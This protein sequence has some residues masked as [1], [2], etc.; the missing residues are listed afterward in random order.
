MAIKKKRPTWIPVV[1]GLIRKN[2][3]LLVGLRPTG[4]S[5]AGVWEFPGGKVEPG[6]DPIKA[7]RRELSEELGIEADVGDLKFVSSHRYGETNILLMFFEVCYWRGE[8][9]PIHHQDLRW[10]SLS[11]LPKLELPEA[12][13][14]VLPRIR[15]AL[16]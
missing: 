5:M 4:A 13:R 9:K 16:E 7:L 6:E 2:G 10:I 1:T 14:A 8:P 15:E 11:E 12:N 3:D